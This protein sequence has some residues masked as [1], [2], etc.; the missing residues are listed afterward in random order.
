MTEIF[1]FRNIS[2]KV[3]GNFVE[4]SSF[5]GTEI[6]RRYLNDRNFYFFRN[7][8]VQVHGNFDETIRN[9]IT[10][11]FFDEISKKFRWDFVWNSNG[12]TPFHSCKST[13]RKVSWFRSCKSTTQRKVPWLPRISYKF[14]AS[15]QRMKMTKKNMRKRNVPLIV[16]KLSNKK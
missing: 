1:I 10:W 14:S 8:S 6:L 2:V 12:Q 15:K 7:I 11:D 3:H 13:Q 16:P 9:C 4:I 5:H